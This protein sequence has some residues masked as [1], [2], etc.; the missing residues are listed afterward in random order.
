MMDVPHDAPHEPAA[1]D[2]RD[3][4]PIESGATA[5]VATDRE[6]G[7]GR[8]LPGNRASVGA[9]GH[10][11]RRRALTDAL[12]RSITPE[13]VQRVVARLVKDAEGGDVASAALVLA[14]GLGKP[15][16]APPD[17]QEDLGETLRQAYASWLVQPSDALTERNAALERELAALRAVPPSLSPAPPAPAPHVATAPPRRRAGREPAPRDVEVEVVELPALPEHRPQTI[18]DVLADPRWT[19]L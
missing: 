18:E 4:G 11:G 13:D 14:Y 12:M 17:A 19:P 8:F 10:G 1:D 15:A 2:P 7:T 3:D 5:T 9:G 6:P 16:A